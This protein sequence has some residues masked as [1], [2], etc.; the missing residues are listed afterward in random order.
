[1]ITEEQAK[2]LIESRLSR[3]RYEHCLQVARV[4]RDMAL[5]FG[6]NG[7]RAYL[8]GLLHDY[9]KGISGQGLIDLAEA[10]N[11]INDP[12]EKK[13]PDLLH[14]PVGAFLLGQ[15]R[16]IEEEDMLQA[17]RLH[18]LGALHMSTLDK[19]IFLADMIEP[20]RD[21]PGLN[22]LQCLAMRDLDQGMLYGLER[23]IRYC[24][25]QGRILHPQ[26]VAVRNRFLEELK[27]TGMDADLR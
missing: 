14:A 12:I 2:K 6:E 23:T 25:D 22:R 9:A 7:D 21:Y 3:P 18:T 1:M 13:V 10:N 8:A 11:L 15:A 5:K 19:I 20:G 16:I 4:A 27:K 26:T 24:L 17:V